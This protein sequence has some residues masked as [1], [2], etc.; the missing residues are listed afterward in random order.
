MLLLTI[1]YSVESIVQSL[2]AAAT[3]L[4]YFTGYNRSIVESELII[5][6]MKGG[7][8]GEDRWISTFASAQLPC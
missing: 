7:E 3:Q 4:V 5:F 1:T 8:S 2:A 6:P